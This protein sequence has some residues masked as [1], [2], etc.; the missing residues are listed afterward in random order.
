MD[1]DYKSNW[2]GN[3]DGFLLEFSR[4]LENALKLGNYKNYVKIQSC[5][6]GGKELCI[7]QVEKSSRPIFIKKE[8][9]KILYV[10]IDNRTEPLEDPEIIR[11]FLNET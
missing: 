8:G 7:V 5:D 9:R 11:E 6:Y 1:Y 4:F 2:K 10:R 3:K